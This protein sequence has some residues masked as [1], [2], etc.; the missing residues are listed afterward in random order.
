MAVFLLQV[1]YLQLFIIVFYGLGRRIFQGIVFND[2]VEEFIA[3]SGL[4]AGL[5]SYVILFLGLA[6]FI[7]TWILALL[8]IISLIVSGPVFIGFIKRI[9][10]VQKKGW[11][12]F[13]VFSFSLFGIAAFL[14]LL[15]CFTPGLETDAFMYHISAPWA[16]LLQGSIRPIPFN[17]HAQFH[18]LIQMLNMGLLALPGKTIA[19]FKLLQWYFAIL[20]AL[21]A[22]LLGRRFGGTRVGEAAMCASLMAQEIG[23]VI[24]GA[25]IDVG[26]GFFVCSGLYFFALGVERRRRM[27]FLLSGLFFGLGFS[28]KNTGILFFSAAFLAFAIL[29]LFCKAALWQGR[30]RYLLLSAAMM[31]FVTL[32]WI[33]KNAFFTGNP[34]YPFCVKWFPTRFDYAMAAQG[35]SDYYS[36][37]KGFN[38]P[39]GMMQHFAG[40]LPL[41]LHN[42]SYIGANVMAV[43]MTLGILL[44]CLKR[45]NLSQAEIFLI[46]ASLFSVPFI[47]LTPFGRFMI[48][49]FPLATVLFC[50]GLSRL[51]RSRFLLAILLFVF[52]TGYGRSFIKEHIWNPWAGWMIRFSGS[53]DQDQGGMARGLDTPAEVEIIPYLRSHP[54]PGHKVLICV[55]DPVLVLCPVPFLPNPHMHSINL[56]KLLLG[57]ENPAAVAGRLD[58]WGVTHLVISEKEGAETGDFVATYFQPLVRTGQMVLYEKRGKTGKMKDL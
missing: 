53:G 32:P 31:L 44:L 43:W 33:L 22:Y 19:L 48:G 1:F 21:V 34:F 54:D 18:F 37:F 35:F 13:S 58:A 38:T 24:K 10:P 52:I 23:I 55:N 2:L 28:S 11:N 46:L 36:G 6:G 15:L 39:L 20:L 7:E 16:W 49:L 51:V 3:C 42:I 47:Y 9:L 12:P 14:L 29:P 56:I 8:F 25:F 26:V 5:Y 57:R 4:G 30:W 50:M 45:R 41:F 27:D 17:L 40:E